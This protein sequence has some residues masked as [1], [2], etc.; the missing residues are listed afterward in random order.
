MGP[1]MPYACQAAT[2]PTRLKLSGTEKQE[3]ACLW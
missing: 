2:D 3:L 1:E